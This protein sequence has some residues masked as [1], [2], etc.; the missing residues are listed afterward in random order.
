MLSR[1]TLALASLCTIVCAQPGLAE[2]AFNGSKF[3]E[4]S[5]QAQSSYI[6]TAAA[7]AGVIATQNKPSVATCVDGWIAA[8]S[9]THFE[10]VLSVVRKQPQYHPLG[11]VLAVLQKQ[12]GSFNFTKP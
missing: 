3:L 9:P 2:E 12:C 1:K 5:Q 4:F 10:P 6:A 11:V 8:N 7:M